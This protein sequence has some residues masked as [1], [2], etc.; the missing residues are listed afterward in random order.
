MLKRFFALIIVFASVV[1]C[2]AG[3]G[4]R[5]NDRIDIVCTVFPIYDWVRNI[6]G[7]DSE[8]LSLSL[9][10]KNGTDPHSYSPSPADIA[11][12]LKADI[13]VMVG[14]ESDSWIID[15]LNGNVN[16]DLTVIK[17]LEV[18][19]DRA[20]LEETVEGMQTDKHDHDH[21]H[22]KE[23]NAYD[24][25]LWLSVKNASFLCKK[26]AD[27][28]K[29]ELSEDAEDIS[30][31]AEEY[32]ASLDALDDRY[33]AVVTEAK[34]EVL[35]FADRFPFRYLTEDYDIEYFAAFSGCSSDSEA[36]F[37]TV[38]F[39]SAKLDE[40][41][42][43]KLVILEDSSA[44]LANTVISNTNNKNAEVIVMDSI[45]TVSQKDIENGVTY[46]S[47]MEKNLVALESALN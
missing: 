42:L 22:E 28:M 38:T 37:E 43:D 46:I 10:V 36:S 24:E 19:G 27:V 32:I 40:L 17:L 7:E 18:L 35:L 30:K 15:A 16:K 5:K 26:I 45:Q 25:H 1:T 9:L 34:N 4:V 29:D 39:L 3:C 41:S 6:V 21:D 2:F 11:A 23:E 14:G 47:V 33:E 8:S 20:F 13:V 44:A 12:I 31:R